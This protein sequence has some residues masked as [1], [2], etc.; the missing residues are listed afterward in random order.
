MTSDNQSACRLDLGPQHIFLLLAFSAGAVIWGSNLVL[1]QTRSGPGDYL[2]LLAV[3]GLASASFVVPRISADPSRFFE[4]PV[5]VTVVSFVGFGLTPLYFVVTGEQ[6]GSLPSDPSDLERALFY[7]MIGMIAFWAG[8]STIR[9]RAG[10]PAGKPEPGVSGARKSI[11]L[12]AVAVYIPALAA[13]VYLLSAH[14]YG[15]T[16]SLELYYAHLAST[17]VWVEVSQL[18]TCA[19]AIAAIEKYRRPGDDLSRLVFYLIF[20]SQCFWGLMSGMKGEFLINFAVVF[21]VASTVQ[22]RLRARWGLAA[23]LALI[24][25]YPLQNPYR[26]IVGGGGMDVT[27]LSDA[28][29]ASELA[30]SQTVSSEQNLGSWLQHGMH[31]TVV[32]LEWLRIVSWALS[33]GSQY[34]GLQTKAYWWTLPLYPFVPRLLW[35]TKPI[36]DEGERLTVVFGGDYKSGTTI[37]YPGDLYLEYGLPGVIVGMFLLGMFCQWLTARLKAG[38]SER[39]LFVF[40]STFPFLTN[41]EA[42]AFGFWVT[43]IKWLAIIGVLGWLVYGRG[44]RRRMARVV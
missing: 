8:C 2:L 33:E 41:L 44:D 1:G 3:Y 29:N 32:R 43:A 40:S 34:P 21:V 27:T 26:A 9:P 38:E 12:W 23:L 35:P 11:A 14:L 15:Y 37:T 24:L 31:S 22:R 6:A 42:D 39:G 10:V 13:K 4:L 7:V 20:A 16:Q 17:Q 5:F 30:F 19:L 18:G 25:L 28:R 36:D